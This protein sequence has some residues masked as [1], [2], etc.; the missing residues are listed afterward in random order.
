MKRYTTLIILIL[1]SI[2][3]TD[4][5]VSTFYAEAQLMV[6]RKAIKTDESIDSFMQSTVFTA[7]DH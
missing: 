4:H 3:C 2:G 6:D 5:R 1:F 7:E